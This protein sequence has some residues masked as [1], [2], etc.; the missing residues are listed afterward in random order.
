MIVQV[1]CHLRKRDFSEGKSIREL[2]CL[3][4]PVLTVLAKVLTSS[5]LRNR[6]FTERKME[7][8]AVVQKELALSILF[9]ACKLRNQLVTL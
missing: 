3:A 6:C 8:E 5:F 7:S 1:N 4:L 9:S 2:C